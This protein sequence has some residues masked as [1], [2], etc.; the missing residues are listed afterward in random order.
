M[1]EFVAM[2][3]EFVV[4]SGIKSLGH[5]EEFLYKVVDDSGCF[6]EF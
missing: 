6:Y 4:L 5:I 3:C 2:D 1:N